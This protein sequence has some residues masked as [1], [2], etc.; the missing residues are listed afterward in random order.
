MNWMESARRIQEDLEGLS[1]FTAT[2]GQGCTRLPF[3]PETRAAADFLLKKMEEAGLE[4]WQDPA[5][6]LFGLLPG[7]NREKPCIL[8]GSH[9]DSVPGGGNY[10]GIAG[11]VCAIELA[12]V[13]RGEG[14]TPDADYLAA[15]FMDEEGCRFGSGYFGSKAVL[16]QLEPG[17]AGRLTDEEG[18]TLARA[19]ERYGLKAGELPKAAW[20]KGRIG[21][22]LEIHIEQGPVLDGQK[23]EL[24]V[25]EGIVGLRR[26]RVA[27]N[28]RAD[29][30]GTTPMDI[31]SLQNEV[32][33]EI[34][35]RIRR[36]L[37]E[38]TEK[39]G[40]SFTMEETLRIQPVELSRPMRKILEESC[41]ER[42][43]SWMALPSGAGHDALAMGQQVDTAMLFVPSRAG[44][45]HCPE[46][47]T[48]P[49]AFGRAVQV[50][51][52]LIV[53]L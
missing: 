52:D 39:T 33:E 27:V 23:K 53:R 36:R 4:T 43:Y 12:R 29:H 48:P 19:M 15:A 50:M 20:P 32:L 35:A 21:H 11:V 7:R 6:N 38:E 42:G 8:C 49:E 13:L 51:K 28:G 37:Q 2:P 16:S 3:T 40:G 26:Y 30:A 34:P 46:E 22:F 24:G 47:Y 44:R 14:I 17:E 1:A 45:S 25:V 10:D 31:R 9:Y 5:G 41:R 18:I